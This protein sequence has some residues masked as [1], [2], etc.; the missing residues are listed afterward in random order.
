M[1]T[2]ELLHSN[3]KCLICQQQKCFNAIF[4]QTPVQW[5]FCCVILR[6]FP[7]SIWCDSQLN[8]QLWFAYGLSSLQ[9]TASC[10]LFTYI[11]IIIAAYTMEC[12]CMYVCIYIAS[13][14]LTYPYAVNHTSIQLG[15]KI[16]LQLGALFLLS[17]YRNVIYDDQYSTLTSE[18]FLW[19][20]IQLAT[21]TYSCSYIWS[22]SYRLTYCSA[23]HVYSVVIA[24]SNNIYVVS[25]VSVCMHAFWF[26]PCGLCN[27]AAFIP[28]CII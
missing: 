3:V 27:Y 6:A 23:M 14:I 17:S 22:W 18:Q 16:A 28:K 5:F 25:D 24:T 11:D 19:L 8:A 9:P 2:L 12:T 13:Y 20:K 26:C 4:G 10:Q 7:L 21:Y 1:Y 15:S